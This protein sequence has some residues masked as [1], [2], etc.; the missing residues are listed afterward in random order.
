MFF[1]SAAVGQVLFLNYTRRWQVISSHQPHLANEALVGNRLTFQRKA[2]GLLGKWEN[3]C[4]CQ[5][6]TWWGLGG[7]V[8]AE[9]VRQSHA[10]TNILA[11]KNGKCPGP[12]RAE[13]AHLELLRPS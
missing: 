8:L 7:R 4:S 12:L 9:V 6:Q 10:C 3:R 1:D 13:V 5:K 2:R 11:G